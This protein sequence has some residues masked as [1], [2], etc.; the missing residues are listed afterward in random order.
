MGS[1]QKFLALLSPRRTA[2]GP[3][4]DRVNGSIMRLF[5]QPPRHAD[6][7][8]SR[9]WDGALS[10]PTTETCAAT[11]WDWVEERWCTTSGKAG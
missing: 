4:P 9:P 2:C 1:L 7:L 11:S 5:L 3:S 10:F 6:G 8:C